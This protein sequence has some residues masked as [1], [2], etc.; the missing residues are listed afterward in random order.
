MT[1]TAALLIASTCLY[2][3]FQWTIRMLVYPQ[4]AAVPA[5]SFVGYERSHQ[6]RVSLTVGPLFVFAGCS[7]I[8]AFV[9]RPGVAAGFAGACCAAILC[10]TAAAAVPQHRRLSAG[11]DEAALRR[12]LLADSLRL[13]LAALACVAAATYALTSH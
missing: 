10:T 12:L 3:G 2:A 1:I 9:A 7:S 6:R 8:A 13:A 4:F 11:F 5:G